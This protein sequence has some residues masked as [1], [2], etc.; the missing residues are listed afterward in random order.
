MHWGGGYKGKIDLYNYD[1]DDDDE[2]AYIYVTANM[3]NQ[4]V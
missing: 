1:D 3:D 2:L 4:L